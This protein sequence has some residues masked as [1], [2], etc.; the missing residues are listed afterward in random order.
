A[1][2]GLLAN[3]Y[4][5]WQRAQQLYFVIRHVSLDF[6]RPARLHEQIEVVTRLKAIRAASFIYDQY[7]RPADSNDIILAK[8]EV[9]VACLDADFRPKAL[10][11]F[12]QSLL[13]GIIAEN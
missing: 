1:A 7:L 8:A 3:T 6:L 10:P 2:V 13:N 11:D 5:Q 4:I 12:L 9:K